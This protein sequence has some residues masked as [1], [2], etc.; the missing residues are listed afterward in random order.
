MESWLSTVL[1]LLLSMQDSVENIVF[2]I[3]ENL[4]IR[5][6]VLH[7]AKES[8]QNHAVFLYQ[9]SQQNKRKKGIYT[10]LIKSVI[11]KK[12]TPINTAA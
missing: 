2:A 7:V 3:C 1:L 4:P 9:F 6:I 11:F 10:T 12:K 5:K 8:G